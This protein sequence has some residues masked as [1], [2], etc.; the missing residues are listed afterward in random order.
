MIIGIAGKRHHG[1]DAIADILVRK[2]GFIKMAISDTVVD[3]CHEC[4]GTITREERAENPGREQETVTIVGRTMS[5]RQVW[6]WF[7][8]EIVRDMIYEKAWDEAIL[9]RIRASDKPVVVTGIRFNSEVTLF[10][11]LGASLWKVV[12]PGYVYAT[13]DR[14]CKHRSESELEG[15]TWDAVIVN[16]GT[17]QDLEETVD[18]VFNTKQQIQLRLFPNTAGVIG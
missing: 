14:D 15:Y 16:D 2:H 13:D 11:E 5:N 17:L 4:F 12:R 1:K 10:R 18:R 9:R 6:M 7:A 3:V 8:T